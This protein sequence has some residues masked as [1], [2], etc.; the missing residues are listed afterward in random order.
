VPPSQSASLVHQEA[1]FPPL[2]I[3]AHTGGGSALASGAGAGAENVPTTSMA[4]TT[5]MQVR[6]C[7]A[8]VGYC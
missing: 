8:D 6:N 2:Q 7:M 4:T 5:L 1:P 3:F